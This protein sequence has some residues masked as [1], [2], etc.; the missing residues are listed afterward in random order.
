MSTNEDIVK[1]LKVLDTRNYEE[2][3]PD[4]WKPIPGT[5]IENECQRCGRMHE[6][7][8]YVQLRDGRTAVIGT[9]CCKQESMDVQTRIKSAMSAAMTASRLQRQLDKAEKELHDY[10]MHLAKVKEAM[11]SVEVVQELSPIKVGYLKGQL[12]PLLR[13]GEVHVPIHVDSGYESA[14]GGATLARR[15]ESEALEL[16]KIHW[17]EHEMQKAGFSRQ[18]YLLEEVVSDLKKRLKRA[19]GRAMEP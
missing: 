9:G 8:A 4:I 15:R 17:I 7:H 13:M 16:L 11:S 5:G 6:V 19:L 14:Y 10:L 18:G 2:V 3:E 12:R 1:V